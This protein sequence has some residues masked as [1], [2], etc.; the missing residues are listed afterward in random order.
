MTVEEARFELS[1]L[2]VRQEQVES[3]ILAILNKGRLP[4]EDAK[5]KIDELEASGME[6]ET[7]NGVK[8]LVERRTYDGQERRFTIL[9]AWYPRYAAIGDVFESLEMDKAA[10]KNMKKS[11]AKNKRIRQYWGIED[12]GDYGDG[13]IAAQEKVFEK[14]EEYTANKAKIEELNKALSLNQPGND[15]ALNHYFMVFL[16]ENHPDTY[17][18]LKAGLEKGCILFDGE[19]FNFLLKVGQVCLLFHHTGCTG[20]K[21]IVKH[22]LINGKEANINSLKNSGSYKLE[23]W[24]ELKKLLKL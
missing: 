6:T 24:V 7:V 14:V 11:Q 12:A 13:Y 9:P 2:T 19:K 23:I 15:K 1:R 17:T 10:V 5:R 8:C 4:L 16:K 3:E 22:I 18:A 21:K 20:V